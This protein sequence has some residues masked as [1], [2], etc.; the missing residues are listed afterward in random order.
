MYKRQGV[1]LAT[2]EEDGMYVAERMQT[3]KCNIVAQAPGYARFKRTYFESPLPEHN[4]PMTVVLE[5]GEPSSGFV[6]SKAGDPVEGARVECNGQ[7]GISKKDG[8]FLVEHIRRGTRRLKVKT[9]GYVTME[10]RGIATGSE[11]VRLEIERAA[12]VR[13]KVLA[14]INATPAG[15][16]VVTLWKDGGERESHEAVSFTHLTLPTTPYV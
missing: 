3:G 8:S 15:D 5:R 10:Q 4:D 7:H 9:S 11:N 16:A 12:V 13:G 14:A 2:E 1:R 6:Y